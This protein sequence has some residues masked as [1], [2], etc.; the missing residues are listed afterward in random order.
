MGFMV[1]RRLPLGCVR[2][3]R[4]R[5][6]RGATKHGASD[7]DF[8]MRNTKPKACSSRLNSSSTALPSFGAF[9]LF[10]PFSPLRFRPLPKSKTRKNADHVAAGTSAVPFKASYRPASSGLYVE[11]TQGARA[12]AKRWMRQNECIAKAWAPLEN[13]DQNAWGGGP[14]DVSNTIE[15]LTP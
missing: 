8:Q 2:E 14:V 15:R 11:T 13:G 4:R 12:P 7:F 1:W 3:C 5:R 10:D 9:S 6:R